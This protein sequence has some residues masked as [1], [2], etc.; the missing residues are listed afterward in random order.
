M[1]CC[2]QKRL[3]QLVEVCVAD[4]L[5][6]PELKTSVFKCIIE[7]VKNSKKRKFSDCFSKKTHKRIIKHKK[8]LTKLINGKISIKTRKKK[9]TQ[10]SSAI[11]KLFYSYILRDFMH[12]CIEHE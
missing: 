3:K 11:Q 6:E 8:F 12:N 1:A 4:K 2:K 7:I 10:A 5:F 9:F